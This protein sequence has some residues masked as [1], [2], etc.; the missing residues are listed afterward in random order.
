MNK[1]YLFVSTYME[2]CF[3]YLLKFTPDQIATSNR[4]VRFLCV[5]S[6]FNSFKCENYEADNCVK[7]K[8]KH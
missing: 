7:N 1:N 2:M 4:I 3:V 6:L 8:Q 5:L